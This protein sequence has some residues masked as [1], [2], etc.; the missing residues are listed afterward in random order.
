[1]LALEENK[2]EELIEVLLDLKHDLGKYIKLPVVMLPKDASS[3][4]LA[5]QVVRAVQETRKSA[6]GTLS[7]RDLF[8]AFDEIWQPYLE[9]SPAY[10]RLRRAINDAEHLSALAKTAPLDLTRAEVEPRLCA[11]SDA[12]VALLRE[13]EGG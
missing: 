13:V 1:M 4:V 9:A 3:D 5:A 10:E 12:I 6:R 8:A 7:A 2:R 11:V